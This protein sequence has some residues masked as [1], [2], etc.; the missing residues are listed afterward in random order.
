MSMKFV[1]GMVIGSAVTATAWMLYS[2]GMLNKKRIMRQY[3]KMKNK[4]LG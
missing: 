4:M 3:R 2:E 1:K